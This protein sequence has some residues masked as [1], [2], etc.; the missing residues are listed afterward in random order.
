MLSQ[1]TTLMEVLAHKA[2]CMTLSEL[3]YL[4]PRGRKHLARGIMSIPGV[5]FGLREWNDALHYVARAPMALSVD[6][7]RERLIEYLDPR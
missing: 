3:R 2:G 6:E 4:S 5:D 7:A 1:P